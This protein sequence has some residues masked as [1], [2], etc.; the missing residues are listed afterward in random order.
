M[1]VSAIVT[2]TKLLRNPPVYDNYIV[3]FRHMAVTETPVRHPMAVTENEILIG[4]SS[5][6]V[7]L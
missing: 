7:Y 3:A 1:S 2:I 4:I 6:H 5:R